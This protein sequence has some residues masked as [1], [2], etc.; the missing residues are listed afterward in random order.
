MGDVNVRRVGIILPNVISGGM[1]VTSPEKICF[2]DNLPIVYDIMYKNK[3]C[4]IK[5]II[6]IK[7]KLAAIAP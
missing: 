7:L 3:A 1:K 2:L 5:H 4:F 6:F